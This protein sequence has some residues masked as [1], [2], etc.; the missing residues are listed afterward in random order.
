MCG[1]YVMYVCVLH[2]VDSISLSESEFTVEEGSKE[3]LINITRTGKLVDDIIVKFVAREIPSAINP[4]IRKIFALL[5]V[6]R[7][8][9]LGLRINGIA[10]NMRKI[11]GLLRSVHALRLLANKEPS[12]FVCIK[13]LK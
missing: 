8:C 5:R 11:I 7:T 9:I 10:I 4:A 6:V 3:V 1:L 12:Q 2:T 13:V